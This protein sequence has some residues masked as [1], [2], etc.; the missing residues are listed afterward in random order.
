MVLEF[1]RWK[2]QLH[3]PT[4]GKHLLTTRIAIM[5][6]GLCKLTVILMIFSQT[7]IYA[8]EREIPV[9]VLPVDD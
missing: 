2:T 9:V 7:D 6:L 5:R 3:L 1:S 8:D 4:S